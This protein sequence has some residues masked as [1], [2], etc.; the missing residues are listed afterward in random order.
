MDTLV[1]DWIFDKNDVEEFLKIN[2]WVWHHI[3]WCKWYLINTLWEIKKIKCSID[4]LKYM[5]ERWMIW[6]TL[7]TIKPKDPKTEEILIL[8]KYLY[9]AERMNT[10]D[11]FLNTNK[12]NPNLKKAKELYFIWR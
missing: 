5:A 1:K 12:Y 7:R 8:C 6:T 11:L 3:I 2:S 10:L 9:K 4:V